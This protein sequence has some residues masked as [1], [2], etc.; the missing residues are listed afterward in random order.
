MRLLSLR[1]LAWLLAAGVI[2]TG[3]LAVEPADAA[4]RPAKSAKADKKAA[5]A[6]KSESGH[7]TYAQY[8]KDATAYW[9]SVVDMR[10]MRIA[11]RNRGEAIELSD[12]VLTQPPHWPG[13]LPRRPL[14]PAT[15]GV[16]RLPLV[17]HMLTMAAEQHSFVPQRASDLEFKRAYAIAATA[18]GITAH[19]AV[20]TYAFETGGNGTYDVQAGLTHPSKKARAISS[21]IG[22]NQLLTAN[23]VGL[24]A[25]H[26]DR[27]LEKLQAKAETL[28]GAERAAMDKKIAATKKM[29]A[30][31]RSV[32][33]Q[34]SE[35]EKLVQ[36]KRAGVGIHAALFDIDLGPL[37][38][39]Q[40]LADSMAFAKS[41]G[42][43]RPLT[44]AELEMMN[45]T[46][47]GNGIDLVTMSDE[48]R[49][50]VPTANFFQRAGYERNPIARR[51]GVVSALYASMNG[52][53]DR[54]SQLP[55]A[56]ELAGA[57][58]EAADGV[59]TASAGSKPAEP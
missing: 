54:A 32:P 30:F 31:C 35:H 11:K 40:K 13:A 24:M 43:A 21:A 23:S 52:K 59:V 44:G 5:K 48:M 57:F 25:A 58:A 29:I 9:Q 37:M 46:G 12:Y 18:A 6:A 16:P 36:T 50:Q 55:G 26:G 28:T 3:V 53:M 22:Y 20:R 17:V 27:F 47:D 34:W 42:H 7:R 41:K 19:Q 10:R 49:Q 15:P 14:P 38:Q 2:A 4:K 8:E 1:S 33:Y 56:V 39:S 45:F 51:T